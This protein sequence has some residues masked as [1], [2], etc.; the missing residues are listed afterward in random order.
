MRQRAVL[1]AALPAG[2][3][4]FF[5]LKSQLFSKVLNKTFIYIMQG[6]NKYF[7]VIGRMQR[8]VKSYG[9]FTSDWLGLHK[10]GFD[11]L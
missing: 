3:I 2:G 4:S 9:S 6:T 8:I 5:S 1:A 7:N 10:R 11:V